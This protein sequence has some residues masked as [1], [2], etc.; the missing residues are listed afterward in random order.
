[1]NFKVGD[2]VK[3]TKLGEWGFGEVFLITKVHAAEDGRQFWDDDI[4]GAASNFRDDRQRVDAVAR[5]IKRG[6]LHYILAPN[7]NQYEVVS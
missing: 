4:L 2:L 1:M 5:C 7:N 6:W 3:R